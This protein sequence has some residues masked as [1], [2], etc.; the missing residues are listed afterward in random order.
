MFSTNYPIYQKQNFVPNSKNIDRK[1]G[2]KGKHEYVQSHA[3]TQTYKYSF[4]NHSNRVS[5]TRFCVHFMILN[6]LSV[7]MYQKGHR[8]LELSIGKMAKHPW[9]YNVTSNSNSGEVNNWITNKTETTAVPPANICL[10]SNVE[11]GNPGHFTIQITN[12]SRLAFI[13]HSS[14]S[15]S[16]YIKPGVLGH[17][18]FLSSLLVDQ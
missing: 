1:L 3:L 18:G 8:K 12:I 10:S 16:Q 9:K 17:L 5:G 14:Q 7:T 4:K 13:L 15:E 11:I 6:I 2:I